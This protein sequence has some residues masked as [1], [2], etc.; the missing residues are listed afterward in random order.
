M[1]LHREADPNVGAAF[2]IATHSQPVFLTPQTAH[3]GGQ[4]QLPLA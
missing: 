4:V 3:F 1:G 2:I